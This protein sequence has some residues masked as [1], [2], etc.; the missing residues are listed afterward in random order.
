MNTNVQLFYNTGI[1]CGLTSD[2]SPNKHLI[3]YKILVNIDSKLF[4]GNIL[5]AVQVFSSP[6]STDM[7]KIII[8]HTKHCEKF[9][10]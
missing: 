7:F 10:R 5:R 2:R 4:L 9:L 1:L 6:Y 3:G 8:G